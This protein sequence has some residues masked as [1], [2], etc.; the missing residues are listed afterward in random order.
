MTFCI[1]APMVWGIWIQFP[2]LAPS[3]K[4]TNTSIT[5]PLDGL[6]LCIELRLMWNVEFNSLNNFLCISVHDL[7]YLGP[8]CSTCPNSQNILKQVCMTQPSDGLYP[9]V[10]LHLNWN[11]EFTIK[12]T[13]CP[14]FGVF[15]PNFPNLPQFPNYN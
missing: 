9:W 8:V 1:S 12:I 15:E 10:R 4:Y 2:Q 3:P 11:V 13:F 5:W 6:Y 14:W 7:G